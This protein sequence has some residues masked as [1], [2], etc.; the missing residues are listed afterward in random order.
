MQ[1]AIIGAGNVGATLGK[2][3]KEAGHTVRW[4][5]PNPDD[6]KYQGLDVTDVGSA[7]QG[8]QIVILAVPWQAA[9]QAVKSAGDLQGKIL[10]DVTNPIAQDFSDLADLGGS[11]AAERIAGW[12]PGAAVVKAFNTIGANVME[13]PTFGDKRATLLVAGD[14]AD[15][16]AAVSGLAQ[17]IGFDPVD[18]GPLRMARHLESFAWIWITLAI[19][20]GQGRD[21]VFQLLRR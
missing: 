7:A 8:A 11:S 9:E 21:I 4:G 13:N 1:V 17:D 12:A 6:A 2:R 10:V 16:K 19:K 14:D 18:A 3:L 15:A 5:V 20:Q